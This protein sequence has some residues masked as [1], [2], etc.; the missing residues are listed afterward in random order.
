[1]NQSKESKN[2]SNRYL[3]FLEFL[4]EIIAWLAIVAF[5]SFFSGIIGL[6]TYLIISGE[7]GY[8]IAIIIGGVGVISS[9]IYASYIWKTKGTVNF[10]SNSSWTYNNTDIED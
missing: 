3:N 4:T 9:I 1:M 6:I 7:I 8:I 2:N 10:I 5:I